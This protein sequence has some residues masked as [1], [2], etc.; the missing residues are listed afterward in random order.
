MKVCVIGAGQS[1]LVSY[2]TFVEAGY[3]VI[4]LE[5]S[6]TNGLYHN[7][8]EKDYF[9]WSSSRYI[10]GFSDISNIVLGSFGANPN[11]MDGWFTMSK[12][13]QI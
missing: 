13:K 8:K 1:G 4:V 10:S 9:R 7:I 3:N 12:K 6:G 2:K 11:I 5:Q